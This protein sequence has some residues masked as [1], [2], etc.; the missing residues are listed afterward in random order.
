[1]LSD[2]FF[3]AEPGRGDQAR[4]RLL[5]AAV[6]VFGEKGPEGASLREIARAAGQNVAAISYYFGGKKKLY[7]AV[8]E[9]LVR[10]L[11][12]R[13]GDVLQP[14]EELRAQPQPSPHEALR[15]FKRLLGA[16]YLRLLSRKEA[17]PLIRLIVREQLGPTAAFEILYREGF[18]TLHE[19][20]CFLTATILG[21]DSRDREVIL[22]THM[23]M[24]Q[25]YFF[26]MSREAILRRAGWET[27]EGDNARLV[28]GLFE[29]NVDAL[30]SGLGA[31]AVGR[32]NREIES[33][34]SLSRK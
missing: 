9:G 1:M 2:A 24:G 4:I 8:I 26:A 31:T 16:V 34:P 23:V 11:R 17:I 32:P 22:R 7:L 33:K 25:I 5:N 12:H 27:L 28:V 14:I 3:V 29:Q 19:S 18:R 21:C 6:T 30:L 10:E 15:L 13:L 20:L